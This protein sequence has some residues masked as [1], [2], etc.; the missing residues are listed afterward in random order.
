MNAEGDRFELPAAPPSS[1]GSNLT[2]DLTDPIRAHI[3]HLPN[4]KKLAS[5]KSR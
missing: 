1:L 4:L 5:G 3:F 2:T